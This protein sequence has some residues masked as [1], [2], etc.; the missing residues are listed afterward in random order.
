MTV[1][2]LQPGEAL[3]IKINISKSKA[4]VLSAR[5]VGLVQPCFKRVE[6]LGFSFTSEVQMER[7]IDRQ[8]G[9]ES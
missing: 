4:I 6:S 7:E 5:N 1:F 3:K 2:G 8:I 9:A